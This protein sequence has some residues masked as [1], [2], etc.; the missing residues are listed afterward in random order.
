M[1]ADNIKTI[2]EKID[3]LPYRAILFD[4]VWGIGK[5]YAI[6]EALKE[7]DNVCK[8]SMFGL[9][10]AR[11]IYHEALF[12]LVLK[13]CISGKIGEIANSFLEGLSKIS[14]KV[15][16][17]KDVVQDI[18]EEKELF[19][20]ASKQFSTYHIIVID[21]LER[22]SDNLSLEEVLGIIE[23]LKK[24]SFVKIVIIANIQ[25][26]RPDSKEVFDKYNEKVIDRIYHITERSEN[27][28]WGKL[29]IHAGF[30]TEFLNIHKVKNLR[31]L[32]K[33][34]NFY[35]DVKL[36]FENIGDEYFLA[37]VRLICY[38]IVVEST[39]NLYYKELDENERN[40]TKKIFDALGNNLDHRILRY[41]SGIKSSS[42]LVN[43]ILKYYQNEISINVDELNTE[44]K[45]YLQTG[46]KPNYYKT[47]E[48][49]KSVLPNLREV[50]KNAQNIGEVNKFA[51][52]YMVWS[53]IVKEENEIILQEYR[54]ILQ[55]LLKEIVLEGK[56][57]ILSYTHDLFHL[58]SEKIKKIYDEE[59][60]NVREF[61]IDTYIEYLQKST[62]GKR[63]YDYSY[64]LKSYFE[65]RFY[66]NIIK[67]KI[68]GLYNRNSFPVDDMNDE[69]YH[70]C[71]N[72][73]YV[74]YHVDEKKFSH[75]CD[76]LKQVCDNMS[77][78]RIEVLV[79]ELTS[80]N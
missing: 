31:T 47:D 72:I 52:E 16:K 25:E 20:L 73:M 15:G 8:I 71:Y 1:K 26:I 34:Q 62:H 38:A 37:E 57:E 17:V 27:V 7:N 76:E 42:N 5:T 41:L 80:N 55:S 77:V 13:G 11:Q 21:D 4:G 51:D 50:M 60:E 53:D 49:I 19:V 61:V 44:Y 9:N 6:D 23:E 39:D 46:Y 33:A 35:D 32:E 40:S 63:A 36:Y 64:K 56:E 75:Y 14:E 66:K 65:S 29:N 24:C 3:D 58:S 18:A 28:A 2:I 30:I 70:T 74:L 45:M 48:E 12:Q 43:M 78:H 67:E 79:K 69:R 10:D 68:E 22:M 59:C 54:N